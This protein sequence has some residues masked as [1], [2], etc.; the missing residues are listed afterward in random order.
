M[1][2]KTSINRMVISRDGIGTTASVIQ[3]NNLLLHTFMTDYPA[4]ILVRR[5]KKTIKIG[6]MEIVLSSGD[7]VALAAGTTCD[8]LNETDNGQ[9]ES[10]WIVFSDSIIDKVQQNFPKHKKLKDVIALKN[11]G[12]EFIQT[13]DRGIQ[14]ISASI[15]DSIAEIRIQE[16]LTWLAQMDIVFSLNTT[17]NLQREVRLKIGAAPD[18]E[19][20][21]KSLADSF[22]MSEATFRRKLAEQGQSFNQILIDVRMTTA[23]T[24]LQV[25]DISISQIAYQVGYESSSR[26]S[27]RFKKRFGFSPIAVRK[28]P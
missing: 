22:A 1:Q 9:F 26:F 24:L 8:L 13:F 4:M 19:W 7:A 2:N 18:K 16:V 21:S 15:P 3:R 14:A 11:L 28:A 10:T 25:T 20:I 6:T 5:G 17:E 27:V 23:L 12:S